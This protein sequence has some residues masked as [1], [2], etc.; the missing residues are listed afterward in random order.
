MYMWI[1]SP[2]LQ[3]IK[4]LNLKLRPKIQMPTLWAF[5]WSA[6]MTHVKKLL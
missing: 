3:N 2:K 4:S 6:N 5:C 1:K